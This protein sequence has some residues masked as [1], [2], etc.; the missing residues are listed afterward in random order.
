MQMMIVDK[1]LVSLE[2]IHEDRILAEIP[3]Q[4]QRSG[5]NVKR[6]TVPPILFR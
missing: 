3:P 1:P 5:F 2:E 6:K 4:R